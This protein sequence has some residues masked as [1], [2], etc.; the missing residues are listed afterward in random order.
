M[1][2]VFALISILIFCRIFI[3]RSIQIDLSKLDIEYAII[4]EKSLIEGSK[5]VMNNFLDAVKNQESYNF[6][7]YNKKFSFGNLNYIF[8]GYTED[9]VCFIRMEKNMEI[10]FFNQIPVGILS[11]EI[12]YSN[13]TYVRVTE[14]HHTFLGEL[15]KKDKKFFKKIKNK[16]FQIVIPL[17]SEKQIYDIEKK[18]SVYDLLKKSSEMICVCNQM[19]EIIFVTEK[20][21]DFTDRNIKH[22]STLLFQLKIKLLFDDN[23]MVLEE[24]I[25]KES[26]VSTW[27]GQ[28]FKLRFYNTDEFFYFVLEDIKFLS[29]IINEKN[30]T[31]YL[32]QQIFSRIDNPIIIG[33]DRV[34]FSNYSLILRGEEF[35]MAQ[36]KI[37]NLFETNEFQMINGNKILMGVSIFER[38]F[39]KIYQKLEELSYSIKKNLFRNQLHFLVFD[40]LNEVDLFML[41]KIQAENIKANL[42]KKFNDR[43]EY[44]YQFANIKNLEI[45]IPS[46]CEVFCSEEVMRIFMNFLLVES[47]WFQFKKKEIYVSQGK[48]TVLCLAIKKVNMKEKNELICQLERFS[49]VQ[50]IYFSEK[51]SNIVIGLEFENFI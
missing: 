18:L 28:K 40:I 5:K 11:T 10:H 17:T 42:L 1:Y 37:T 46:H 13:S 24:K 51:D 34:E 33:K 39:R 22:F 8:K 38:C 2:K 3:R 14:R 41:E 29:H 27:E 50:S 20:L 32:K 45:K 26:I 30:N 12:N 31:E 6:F 16:H 36:K 25:N 44:F 7:D 48:K 35:F 9:G 4:T 47:F 21:L 19:G 49:K 23:L 15:Y 43:M